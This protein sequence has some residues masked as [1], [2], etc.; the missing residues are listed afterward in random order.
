MYELKYF[1]STA[2][3]LSP[4][5][6]FPSA[7]LLR[8]TF[9]TNIPGTPSLLPSVFCPSTNWIP[10]L[11]KFSPAVTQIEKEIRDNYKWGPQVAWCLINFWFII[12]WRLNFWLVVLREIYTYNFFN[13]GF[14]RQQ[15]RSNVS[16][17]LFLSLV[18]SHRFAA[19]SWKY[20]AWRGFYAS[21]AHV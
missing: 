19:F 20:S 6:S 17:C 3:I 5:N 9:A 7:I 12:S 11:V 18:H 14:S 1:Y 10:S 2:N 15:P 13:T 8:L 4:G 21:D 16:Q